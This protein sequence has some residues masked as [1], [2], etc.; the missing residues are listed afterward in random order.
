MTIEIPGVDAHKGLAICDGD[1]NMYIKFLRLYVSNL[2]K[3]LEK[4][5]IV[6]EETLHDYLIN[7]HGIKGISETI[8]AEETRSTARQLEAIA[9]NGDLAGLLA[10]NDPFIK[11]VENLVNC[12][13]IWL[14]KNDTFPGK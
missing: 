3:I 12:I 4:I 6:S 14:E 9:R 11:S 13:Q 8:G 5:R 7:V 2:P 1:Q 10:Q